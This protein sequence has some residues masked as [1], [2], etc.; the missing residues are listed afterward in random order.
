MGP[1]IG[2]HDTVAVTA[3]CPDHDSRVIPAADAYIDI[4]LCEPNR[5]GLGSSGQQRRRP[6]ARQPPSRLQ[7]MRFSLSFL[8]GVQEPPQRRIDKIVPPP[9][10]E[11]EQ[12]SV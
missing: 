4:S 12:K 9:E 10:S 2:D 1:S 6:S 5:I 3:G 8:S 7:A 11:T